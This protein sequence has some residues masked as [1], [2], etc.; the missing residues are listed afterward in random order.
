[1]FSNYTLIRTLIQG[2]SVYVLQSIA[3]DDI[4]EREAELQ[5]RLYSAMKAGVVLTSGLTS[6]GSLSQ[7][8]ELIGQQLKCQYISLFVPTVDPMTMERYEL[9]RD[10]LNLES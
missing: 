4:K 2:F 6:G 9:I 8:F 3:A 10:C 5:Q 7:F 1:M